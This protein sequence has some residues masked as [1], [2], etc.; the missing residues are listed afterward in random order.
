MQQSVLLPSPLIH[1]LCNELRK[2]LA[3]GKII[4]IY[5]RIYN[6]CFENEKYPEMFLIEILD[7]I[8]PGCGGS[9]DVFLGIWIFYLEHRDAFA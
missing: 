7:V 5:A 8:H 9:Y 4:C 2:S 1:M 3:L 6:V